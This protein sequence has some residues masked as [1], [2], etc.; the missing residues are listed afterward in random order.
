MQQMNIEFGS[1]L[2][3]LIQRVARE[4]PFHC[5]YQLLA[6]GSECASEIVKTLEKDGLAQIIRQMKSL[7]SAYVELAGQK[8][9]KSV[10]QGLRLST[11]LQISQIS[12]YDL[13]PVITAE[14]PLQTDS[15]F[16]YIA[17]FRKTFDLV[18]GINQPKVVECIGSL[19]NRYMQLVKGEQVRD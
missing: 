14:P 2:A 7:R 3:D 6:S 13:I 5:V 1:F 17:G 11:Q 18:G 12:E 9:E 8:F 15:S 16:E 10:C 19:G 4:H